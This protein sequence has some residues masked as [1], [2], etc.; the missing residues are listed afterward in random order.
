MPVP[1][2]HSTQ[3]LSALRHACCC[4]PLP[5]LLQSSTSAYVFRI[6]LHSPRVAWH[7]LGR[8]RAL[9]GTGR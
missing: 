8:G 7:R 6:S 5:D 3:L 9:G 4:N 2:V 1:D